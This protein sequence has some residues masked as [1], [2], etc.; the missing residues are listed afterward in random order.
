MGEGEV[1]GPRFHGDPRRRLRVEMGP[2]LAGLAFFVGALRDQQIGR[3]CQRHGVFAV[4]RVRAVAE[5]PAVDGDP[6]A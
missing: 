6:E 5:D 4:A 1:F 2:R 3:P